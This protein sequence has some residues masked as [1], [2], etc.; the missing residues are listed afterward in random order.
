LKN[1]NI[2]QQSNVY[3]EPLHITP[4]PK[5]WRPVSSSS[6]SNLGQ[7]GSQPSELARQTVRQTDVVRASN[8]QKL[9]IYSEY[10]K[11]INAKVDNMSINSKNVAVEGSEKNSKVNNGTIIFDKIR[12]GLQ[13]EGDGFIVS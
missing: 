12:R 1:R 6:A 13:W 4:T 5:E 7:R 2:Q 10:I 11:S 3:L 9:T 8:I